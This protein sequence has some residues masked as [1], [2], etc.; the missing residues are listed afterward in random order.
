MFWRKTTTQH[1]YLLV[2]V[3]QIEVKT[4]DKNLYGQR[5]VRLHL[6]DNTVEDWT[7]EDDEWRALQ[8][9]IRKGGIVI[10]A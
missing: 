3:L 7:L 4:S 10:N 8:A 5:A 9:G 2:A 6:A 1:T